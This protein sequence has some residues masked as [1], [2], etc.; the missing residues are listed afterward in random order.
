M[1]DIYNLFTI[2]YNIGSNTLLD[3]KT[4]KGRWDINRVIENI[5]SA[6][7]EHLAVDEEKE[8]MH[9]SFVC[10][11]E[12]FGG[13]LPVVTIERDKAKTAGNCKTN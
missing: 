6:R 2:L 3:Y 8:A 10:R 7:T 12:I 1:I 4:T 11:I 5:K 9:L 13:Y